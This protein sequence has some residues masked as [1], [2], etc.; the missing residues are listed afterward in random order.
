MEKIHLFGKTFNK[1]TEHLADDSLESGLIYLKSMEQGKVLVVQKDE[2][3]KETLI[4]DSSNFS[5]SSSPPFRT[6]RVFIS[7]CNANIHQYQ[8]INFLIIKFIKRPLEYW[9]ELEYWYSRL[10][11]CQYPVTN[12]KKVNRKYVNNHLVLC[13][14]IYL[15]HCDDLH[16]LLSLDLL[17]ATVRFDA[18]NE[19]NS[20][21]NSKL[22][23]CSSNHLKLRSGEEGR[24]GRVRNS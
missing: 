17:T 13:L 15:S 7:S 2:I 21:S 9:L 3:I 18:L 1:R 23:S 8:S 20:F 6:E 11:Q 5:K 14:F 4:L 16:R 24:I 12:H 22:F 10:Y 19:L